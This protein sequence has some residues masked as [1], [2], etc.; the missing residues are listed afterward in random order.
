MRAAGEAK[1]ARASRA[2]PRR[3]A[4]GCVRERH[5]TTVV[6]EH[7]G[8]AERARRARRPP[9]WGAADERLAVILRQFVEAAA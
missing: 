9:M 3:E 4:R 1:D 8:G 2:K 5:A 6:C 7:E